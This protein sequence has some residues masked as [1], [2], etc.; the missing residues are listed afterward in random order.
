MTVVTIFF[1]FRILAYQTVPVPITI[2]YSIWIGYEI[3]FFSVPFHK[4][5]NCYSNLFKKTTFVSDC[6]LLNSHID[7]I[8]T[9]ILCQVDNLAKLGNS[10]HMWIR[11][12]LLYS[13]DLICRLFKGQTDIR[14]FYWT[15]WRVKEWVYFN[16]TD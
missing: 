3:P 14:N 10:L 2:T 7:G 1:L 16:E 15:R 5:H 8:W 4:F 6:Y 11:R 13:V 9:N 12:K